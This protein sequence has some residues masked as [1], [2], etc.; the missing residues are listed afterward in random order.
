MSYTFSYLIFLIILGGSFVVTHM[1]KYDGVVGRLGPSGLKNPL[2]VH[3][4]ESYNSNDLAYICDI[5]IQ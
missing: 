4:N 3:E 5:D 1:S 2:Q